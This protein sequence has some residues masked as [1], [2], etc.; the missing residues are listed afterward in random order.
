MRIVNKKNLKKIIALYIVFFVGY[1]IFSYLYPPVICWDWI[2]IEKK[3][4][5]DECNVSLEEYWL[6]IEENS[7]FCPGAKE[8]YRPIGWCEPDRSL[9]IWELI[10]PWFIFIFILI[11]LLLFYKSMRE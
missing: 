1:V 10:V 4:L 5:M 8:L 6:E 7:T 11:I 2:N 9:V 3:E